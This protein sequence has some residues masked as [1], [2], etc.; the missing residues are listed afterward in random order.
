MAVAVF[1]I[2]FPSLICLILFICQ[3]IVVVFDNSLCIVHGRAA[4]LYCSSVKSLVEFRLFREM[5]VEHF[6]K[7]PGDVRF[8]V[9][10]RIVD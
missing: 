7:S 9:F 3:S 1:P 5:F 6:E 10:S 8:D 2:F 4:N